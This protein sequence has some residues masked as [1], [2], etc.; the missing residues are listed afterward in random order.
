MLEIVLLLRIL[1]L[2][3]IHKAIS[4]VYLGKNFQV[5]GDNL[6]E[7]PQYWCLWQLAVAFVGL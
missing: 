1:A 7:T 3:V 4:I 5:K 2:V 6:K